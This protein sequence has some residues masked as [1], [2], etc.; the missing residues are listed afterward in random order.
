MP[1]RGEVLVA[2][3]NNRLDFNL[4]KDHRWYRI[5]TSS[6]QKWLK[7]CWP[8]QWL[9]FY[10]TK[11]F[12]DEAFAVHYY[13]RVKGIRVV[14]R[15]ELFP[16][17]PHDEKGMRRYYQVALGPMKQLPRPI[18]SRRWRRIV[19][20]PTTL[21]KFVNADE[22]NDLYHDSPL[23]DLLWQQLKLLDIHAERQEFIEI[24]D[25]IY[26]LD[27]VV[28][29]QLGRLDIETD[30]DTWHSNPEKAVLDNQRDNALEG[31]GWSLLRFNTLQLRERMP[32]YCVPTIVDTVNSLGGLDEGGVIP[33]RIELNPPNGLQ[34]LGL[35]DGL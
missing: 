1:K 31:A 26:V 29:C 19:F 24:G 20:I 11:V 8:P 9:A 23:E 25:S 10:Q 12:G 30:G 16:D 17:E 13:A 22:I 27:F 35:F 34:Q 5:P 21:Q 18:R 7:D 14:H 15:W 2:I 28:Y 3:L 32:E 6:V 4:A 33:R